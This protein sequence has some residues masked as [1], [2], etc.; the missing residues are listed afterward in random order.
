MPICLFSAEAGEDEVSQDGGTWWREQRERHQIGNISAKG[1]F[2]M[3]AW[4]H[5]HVNSQT[6][7][8]HGGVGEG[9]IQKQT[10]T[11]RTLTTDDRGSDLPETL[12]GYERSTIRL[13]ALQLCGEP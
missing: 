3:Q 11:A 9:H 8:G 4:M 1:P 6:R 13:A 10:H 5:G 7:Q 2:R 12:L